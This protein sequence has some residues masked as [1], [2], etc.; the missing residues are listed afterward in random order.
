MDDDLRQDIYASLSQKETDE[1]IE[2]W[3]SNDHTQWTDMGFEV[4]REIL[5]ERLGAL[6]SQNGP[7]YGTVGSCSTT[8]SLVQLYFSFSGRIGRR[9]YWLKGFLPLVVL[10][11]I[12]GIIA[13]LV[14]TSNQYPGGPM[15]LWRL[16]LL[17]PSLALT[18]KRW[19]DLDKSGWWVLIG[20]IPIVG[21]I[22][23]FLE[24]GFLKGTEGPNRFGL[25]TF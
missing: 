13:G 21:M 14:P 6:P 8:M 19:H 4:I 24:T 12:G 7:V 25:K 18:V 5:Q 22:W 20:L 10:S 1:L 17:W 3:R 23:T 2:I 15:I 9:T 11:V 16:F